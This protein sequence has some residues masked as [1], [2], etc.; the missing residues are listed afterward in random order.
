M[1]EWRPGESSIDLIKRADRALLYGKHAGE[2]GTALCA[3]AVPEA[4]VALSESR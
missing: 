4:Q 1:A 2:R 3:S